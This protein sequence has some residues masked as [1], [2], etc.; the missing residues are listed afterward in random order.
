MFNYGSLYQVGR[1]T[2]SLYHLSNID[3]LKYHPYVK[4]D[5]AYSPFKL[6]SSVEYLNEGSI[7]FDI[8]FGNNRF[9]DT[10]I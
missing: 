9:S 6:T 3:N 1:Q 5:Y 10:I 8:L 7:F 4:N 2:G